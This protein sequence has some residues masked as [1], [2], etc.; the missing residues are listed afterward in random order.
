MEKL[1]TEEQGRICMCACKI[2]RYTCKERKRKNAKQSHTWNSFIE[3]SAK[4]LNRASFG[5][6][7]K[8]P[9]K[10]TVQ[11]FFHINLSAAITTFFFIIFRLRHVLIIYTSPSMCVDILQSK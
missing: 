7:L 2:G 10:I 4:V 11:V 5:L 3:L 8:S 9:E 6:I 1:S